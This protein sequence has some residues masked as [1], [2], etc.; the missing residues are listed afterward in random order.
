MCPIDQYVGHRYQDIVD[1]Q[2]QELIGV[3]HGIVADGHVA[4][5]E[6]EYL[7]RWLRAN[8]EVSDHSV[9]CGLL[10]RVEEMLEDAHLDEEEAAEL[11]DTLVRLTGAHTEED[12]RQKST[13]L[14]FDDPEP[15]IIFPGSVFVFTGTAEFGTRQACGQAVCD[16]GGELG[17]SI[18]RATNYVV[19]GAHATPSWK[20]SS[21]GRK[22][23]RA[24]DL[25][26]A[27]HPLSIVS[28][29]HWV[30]A[31]RA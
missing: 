9:I 23:E 8:A 3:C 17:K 7:R 28:E 20:H 24:A 11:L 25:R 2:I 4:Q 12:A 10:A 26:S 14:P 18:T 21:F 1:R 5:G 30:A 19:I 15:T 16:L 22:I 29:A 31:L 13:G 6:V 27:G